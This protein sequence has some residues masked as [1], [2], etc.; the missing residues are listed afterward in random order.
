MK[1]G[2]RLRV[3]YRRFAALVQNRK[4]LLKTLLPIRNKVME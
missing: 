2:E 4:V 1:E 3:L